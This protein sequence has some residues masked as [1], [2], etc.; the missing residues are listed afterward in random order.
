MTPSLRPCDHEVTLLRTTMSFLDLSLELLEEITY[1]VD[2]RSPSRSS[3]DTPSQVPADHSQLR[4]VCRNLNFAVAPS[5]F[6]SL[7]LDVHSS[8]LE[9]GLSH[10][11]TLAA[12]NS[13][14]SQFAHTLKIKCLS[15]AV[16]AG[17][18]ADELQVAESRLEQSLRPALD[19][20]KNVR[21]VL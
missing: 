16:A 3:A 11:E 18:D 19:S 17:A 12:G 5:F 6:S 21:T 20:L 8:R 4:M 14:W 15:P 13:Q 7:V 10:L 9:L 2:Y 1:W